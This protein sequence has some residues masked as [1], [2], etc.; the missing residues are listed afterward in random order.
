[1]I[2]KS[3]SFRQKQQQK[4][5]I[6]KQN[7]NK[8]MIQLAGRRKGDGKYLKLICPQC[9]FEKKIIFSKKIKT[10]YERICQE[11]SDQQ[12]QQQ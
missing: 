12:Q 4:S 1:M 3:Q 11:V 5:M 9:G 8:K 7:P 6:K 10:K 2:H